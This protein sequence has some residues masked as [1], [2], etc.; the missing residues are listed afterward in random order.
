[1][2]MMTMVMTTRMIYSDDIL[3]ILLL[4]LLEEFKEQ[5]LRKTLDYNVQLNS[6]QVSLVPRRKI[7]R[8]VP[9]RE[10]PD[11]GCLVGEEESFGKHH[12]RQH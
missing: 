11:N 5:K 12:R 9:E 8:I 2:A 6:L 4:R 10:R 3:V 1:M 7:M